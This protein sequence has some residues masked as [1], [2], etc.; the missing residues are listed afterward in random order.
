MM[1]TISTHGSYKELL[2]EKHWLEKRARILKRD[3]FRCVICGSDKHLVVHHK[4][5]HI[6]KSTGEKFVPWDYHDKYLITL[7][8]NC[9]NKG[10]RLYTVP[11]FEI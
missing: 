5:Y 2:F 4:Q 7:C 3:S 8:E 11:T 9:H 1:Q 6:H 10:H